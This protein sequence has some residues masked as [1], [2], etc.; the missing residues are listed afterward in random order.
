MLERHLK[1]LIDIDAG[2]SMNNIQDLH[3]IYI[4]FYQSDTTLVLENEF[5]LSCLPFTPV[6]LKKSNRPSY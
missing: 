5:F 2:L 3:N 1:E 6:I 4:V